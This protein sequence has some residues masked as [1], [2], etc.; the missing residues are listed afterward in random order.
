MREM[1]PWLGLSVVG[2]LEYT[3]VHQLVVS[4]KT[5]FKKRVC[6][7][8]PEKFLSALTVLGATLQSWSHF[9]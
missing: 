9:S 6:N 5:C 1:R 4:N 7:Q 8:A 3:F 2:D